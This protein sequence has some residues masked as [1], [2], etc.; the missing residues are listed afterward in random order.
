MFGDQLRFYVMTG[1]DLPDLR[2]DYME[3][4]GRSPVPPRKALGLWVSEF[5]YDNWNQIDE[6]LAGLRSRNFPVDGFVLDLNWFGGVALNQPNRSAMGRL[7]WDENQEPLVA[8]GRYFF[9]NPAAKVRQYAADQ[10]RLAAIEESY[11]ANTTNTFRDMPVNLSAYQRT[12]GQCDRNLQS[13]P[14]EINASDFW[15]I[16]RMIDWSDPSA[17]KWWHDQRRF[18][19]LVQ[20]GINVHWTD[21]GE[22]ERF[23]GS[24]C[25]E[26][27]EPT[28]TGVK[29]EHADI[30]NLYNLLALQDRLC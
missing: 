12:N 17:G 29:N 27:V 1:A 25:Y 11:L 7:S 9:P 4:T 18:P 6:L 30:H 8:D 2:R 15:G 13:N 20:L 5:G 19:N 22:P 14:I 10:V 23:D 28:A 3:L 26:G 24:A 16:G 21:L